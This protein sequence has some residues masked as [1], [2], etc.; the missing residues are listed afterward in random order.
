MPESLHR[1]PDDVCLIPECGT[2]RGPD[3]ARGMC[4]RC[5]ASAKKAVE[6]GTM[7]WEELVKM[8]LAIAE[9]DPFTKA[10]NNR[11]K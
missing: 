8:G 7:T 10:V 9:S 2:R 1:Q 6:A 5:Y 11:R 3:Y 4:L